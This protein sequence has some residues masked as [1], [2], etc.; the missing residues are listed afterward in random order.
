MLNVALG[1]TLHQ[2]LADLPG[3]TVHRAGPGR[4]T[5]TEIQTVPGSMVAAILGERGRVACHHH[6]AIDQVA[7]EL[8]VTARS[9]DGVVEAVESGYM[10][11]QLVESNTKRIADVESGALPVVGVN[12]FTEGLPSPLTDSAETSFMV[13]DAGA[14]AAQ[15]EEL[16]AWRARR[17]KTAVAEEVAFSRRL[18]ARHNWP[19]I[20][21]TRRSI[22]E[23]AAAVMRLLTER[24]RA[25]AT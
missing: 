17:D 25:P 4:F 13:P 8:T 12:C 15:I 24:R 21:V 19:T 6:Q 14:E 5:W 3:R 22:E 1:G 16:E 18:C 20:D 10:K 9:P 7:P 2:H 23:T 11:Q